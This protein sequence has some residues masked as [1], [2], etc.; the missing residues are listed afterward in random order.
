MRSVVGRTTHP[1][2]LYLKPGALQKAREAADER[3]AAMAD[4]EPRFDDEERERQAR[5]DAID[6]EALDFVLRKGPQQ[7]VEAAA[8]RTM[9]KPKT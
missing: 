8:S 3:E 1:K 9:K 2:P 5:I 6:E 4:E 7:D